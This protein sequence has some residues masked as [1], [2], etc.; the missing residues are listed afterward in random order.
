MPSDGTKGQSMTSVPDLC[1]LGG[2]RQ[3]DRAEATDAV[4]KGI[5][6]NLEAAL[7][8]NWKPVRNL[9]SNIQLAGFVCFKFQFHISFAETFS[10]VSTQ[11]A[12]GGWRC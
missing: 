9:D 3:R 10:T 11:S 8:Q 2:K 5:C 6:R 1:C 4:E 12:Q 7:V